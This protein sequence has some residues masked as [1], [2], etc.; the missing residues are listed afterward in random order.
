MAHA[1]QRVCEPS[2]LKGLYYLHG[3]MLMFA[4]P[5]HLPLRPLAS[6]LSGLTSCPP[7]LYPRADV[8][9]HDVGRRDDVGKN[10]EDGRVRAHVV[11]RGLCAGRRG[12]SAARIRRGKA[13]KRESRQPHQDRTQ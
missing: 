2:A 1:G 10:V 7:L 5:G 12:P 11:V 13:E 4:S 3:I 8:S 9:V 6:A